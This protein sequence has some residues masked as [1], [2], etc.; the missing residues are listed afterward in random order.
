MLTK[1][2]FLMTATGLLMGYLAAGQSTTPA[3][4]AGP[5][6]VDLLSWVTW[7]AAG[8]V[9]LMGVLV[10]GSLAS[11][12]RIRA[13]ALSAAAEPVAAVPA[14]AAAPAAAKTAPAPAPVAAEA[15]ITAEP[16][17]V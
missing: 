6:P 17:L 11:A 3:P 12:G 16:V 7:G 9:L 1:R 5:S 8:V 14:I 15:A 13:A 2:T 10:A 4:A